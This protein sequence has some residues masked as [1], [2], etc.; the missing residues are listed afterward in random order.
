MSLSEV[1]VEG[2]LKSDGTLELDHKPNLPP[3]RVQVIVQAVPDLPAG[4]PFWDMMKSIWAEQK[5]RGHMPRSIEEVEAERRETREG[6]AR[7]QE[8]I[9]RLQEEAR[10]LREQQP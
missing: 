6:W 4:D 3:G 2:I 5:A 10:R 9:E 1:V 7:R 8:A